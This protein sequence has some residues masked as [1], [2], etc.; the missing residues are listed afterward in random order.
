[1][2]TYAADLFG[3]NRGKKLNMAINWA[4]RGYRETPTVISHV[5]GFVDPIADIRESMIVETHMGEG[6]RLKHLAQAYKPMDCN[7]FI[8]RPKNI[9]TNI[10]AK[11]AS[12]VLDR[13]GA[14]YGMANVVA[15]ALDGLLAKGLHKKSITL[16]RKLLD[17]PDEPDCSILWAVEYMKHGYTFGIDGRLAT[18]DDMWDFAVDNPDKYKII[19]VS[20]AI[21]NSAT[22]KKESE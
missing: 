11:I 5:G 14:K 2:L 21:W 18:P 17:N 4:T 15:A 9:A 10:R 8:I 16:A 20:D 1:M 22:Q 6:V 3:T 13:L 19:P 12:A 7:F